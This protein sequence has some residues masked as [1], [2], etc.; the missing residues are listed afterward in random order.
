MCVKKWRFIT[1]LYLIILTFFCLRGG[2]PPD[3]LEPKI[4]QILWPNIAHIPA[5]TILT[6][7]LFQSFSAITTKIK[8]G[9]FI[10]AFS[11][12]VL[13]EFLQSFVPY[14]SPSISDIFLNSLGILLAFS[15]LQKHLTAQTIPK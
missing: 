5:Y 3:S 6:Y 4:S 15:F 11:F 14:R 7:C 13:I 10:F 2:T 8:I 9:I 12:G 1:V